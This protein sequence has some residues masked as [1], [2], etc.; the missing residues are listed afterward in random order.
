MNHDPAELI[1]IVGMA[2]RFPGA[3]DTESLW[4]LMMDRGNAIRPVPSERWDAESQLDPEKQVQA[5]G[6][7][8]EDVDQFDPLFFGISPREVEDIDPQQ[9]LM[10]EA[11]WRALE[12]SGMRAEDLRGSRTGVY[13]GAQWHDYELVRKDAGSGA[14]E[15]SSVGQAL[16]VIAAR[17]SYFMRFTG[18]SLTVATGCSSS[19]VALHLATQALRNGEIE[20]AVVGGVNLMLSPDVSIGLTHFGG[21]SPDGR[22]AAFSAAANGFVRGE[23]VAALYLKTLERALADGD[24]VHAVIV[25]TV[26]NNDGGGESLVTPR[27]GAQEDLLRTAYTA[28]GIPLDKLAYVEAHGTG[29]RRGDPVEAGA[30]GRVIGQGR[31]SGAG[32]IAVGSVKSNIGHLEPASGMAG[33]FKAVLSLEHRVVPPSLHADELNPEIPFDELNVAVVREPLPLPDGDIYVGVNSFGWGGTNGHAV[34]M[35]APPQAARGPRP[36][37]ARTPAAEPPAAGTPAVPGPVLVPLSG[38]TDEAL[39]RRAEDIRELV[40]SGTSSVDALA[41]TLAWRR[42]SFPARA[43]FVAQ[44]ADGLADA[45]GR[46]AAD[47]EEEIAGVVTGR[48]RG[49]GR[50]AF[51]FPGQGSQWAR[52]GSELYAHKPVFAS[53]IHRCAKALEPYVDWD[54]AEI[55]SGE[56]GDAWLTRNDMVQP[57]LWAVSV[58]IAEMWRAAGVE[59]DVVIGHSQGE[60]TAATVAGILSYED[61]ALIIARR[62]AL[63]ARTSGRGRMLAVELDVAAAHQALDGFEGLVSLAVNNGPTSCVLSGDTD[64]VEALKE[65]LEAEGVFCRMVNV[66][67]ASHSPQMDELREDLFAA[68][69]SVGPK[70]GTI[71]LMSTVRVAELAGPEMDAGY[72]VD[73][74]RRPVLFADAMSG[75]FDEGITHVVEISPHAV[76]APAIERLAALRDDQPAVLTSLRRDAGSPADL[77]TAFARAYV[78]GLAPFGGLPRDASAPVPGYPWQRTSYWLDT[79]SRR[80]VPRNGFDFAL[81]PAPSEHD[82]WQGTLELAV[83]SMPWLEDHKVDDA[84][85]LPGAGM[86][87]LALGAARSR[88]G[89]LPAT[90]SDVAFTSDL[91]LGDEPARLSALWRD[92]IT[93][94]GSFTLLSLPEGETAWTVH[95]TARTSQR[96]ERP[97]PVAFPAHLLDAE[98]V[99]GEEFYAACAARG[100]HYGPAFQGVQRLYTGTSGAEGTSRDDASPE[101]ASHDT[102][103]HDTAALAEVR[104]SDRCRAGA[105]PH[106]LHPALWD[107]ALQACLALCEDGQTVVPTAVH[108]V[109]VLREMAEPVL[110]LWSYAVRRAGYRFDLYFF[111]GDR[112]PLMIM[113]GLELSP[114]AAGGPAQDD[115]ERE[116]RLAFR[117]EPRPEA[118]S[119]P[120]HWFVCGAPTASAGLA[121]AL[122]AA[123]A[124][125]TL[126]EGDTDTW[127]GQL[128]SAGD[129]TGVV[130]A[131]PDARAGLAAQRRALVTLPAVI[132][133]CV[134]RT[135]PPR[136]ALV[137]TAA[138]AVDDEDRPDPGAALF[139]G[140]SRVLRREHSELRPMVIDLAPGEA[141]TGCAAELLTGD[142]EDQVAL[143]GGRRLVGR[144][145]RGGPASDSETVAAPWR[146][147]DQPFRLGSDRPGFWDSLVYRP[148]SRTAPGPGEIEIEITAA[149]LNFIDVMKAMGTYPDPSGAASLLGGECAGRVGAVGEGVTGFAVGD[150]VVACAMG[151]IASHVT[152]LAAHAQA[153]PESLDD[154]DAAALPLVMGTAWYGLV[155]LGRLT[156]GERVLIHSG[157]GGLG[158]AAIQIAKALGAE[159]IATAGSEDKRAYLRGLGIEHV[160]D[161]RNLSW[162]EGVR[163]ATGG[164]GV[165]VVLNSLTGAAIPLGL[166]A[167]AEDGRFIEVG[168]KDIYG[169]RN[170]SLS[171]FRK[172]ISFAAVDLAGLMTRRPERFARVFGQVWE[173]VADGR[174][175]PLPVLPYTFADAAEALREM[176]HGNHIGKF[177]LAGPG[178][179]AG[180]APEAMPGGRF[181]ADASYL[182]TGGLGALGLSLA[183]FLAD[184]GAGALALVSRSQPG[185]DAAAR[186]GELRERGVRVET[187]ACDVSDESA[188]RETLTRLRTELPPLRGVVHAAGLLDDA[189]VLNARPEQ[190]E[191]VLAPKVDGARHLD[192]ATANDPLDFFVMFSSAAALV[193]NTGQ[194]AYAAGNAYMDTLAEARRRRGFPALSVQW[195]PFAE[196]GLAAE[197][198]GRGARLSDRGM[199]SFPVEDAWAAL[200]RFLGRD[201]QVVGYVPLNLRQWFDAYP[202]TAA[203]KSWHLLRRAL[204][205][206]GSSAAAGGEFRS[207]FEAADDTARQSLVEGRV[208]EVAARVMRMDPKAIDR[209]TPFKSLGLDSL[210]SLEL[211]NRLESAFGLQLSPTLLWTYGNTRALSGVLGERLLDSASTAAPAPAASTASSAS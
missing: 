157:T 195:G 205:E 208:R 24:Q 150:R 140:F 179:V 3:P 172:G 62:S 34:L 112:E 156:A 52:M 158:L 8:L 181:R 106:T 115:S 132:R 142:G 13:V 137:T 143:R 58:G 84:V 87:A 30:I 177:V 6:G 51:V 174:I 54:L 91:T 71:P 83:D 119:A 68:L 200:V 92:D 192:A 180:V 184:R 109:H 111:T 95:A 10:L 20:G 85:V 69:A 12:D 191:R 11:G 33:L 161:S 182:L 118:A 190:I 165:D 144:L 18:P 99:G 79:G 14:T 159:V 123:G 55:V 114:L 186:I 102:A 82:T 108:R 160:F 77:T 171:A 76:L 9:R 96:P 170:I 194:A 70:R 202:D 138:Q 46:F 32:P 201:Q 35:S 27:T 130:F 148:L 100:L 124:P 133:A 152:V 175:E 80:S 176:S 57:T 94:G 17:L 53:V 4:K 28:G 15:R 199:D 48:A 154:T 210:M 155:E 86:V 50:T 153:V 21:L 105:R 211:R 38:H 41:G 196:I 1:A 141:A 136:F 63:A 43:A 103:P 2:G 37:A 36:P 139:W 75:L 67:Y 40:A 198:D 19:M 42:D 167:L 178:T 65:I 189:T 187:Y 122:H 173:L 59:P 78:S 90:L 120:G 121:E 5:V 110:D 29:T 129:I 126:A 166:D 204:Q 61:G 98:P 127:A 31:S 168:K 16:D 145:T 56:A 45:L 81:T 117:E 74:L 73:N 66:D 206:G 151:A 22:C 26:V 93:E 60:V 162:A 72:W 185:A 64:A 116:H 149:A 147:S 209:E 88:H 23:G 125:V 97:A 197:D 146:T 188:V 107:G 39:R 47:P 44:D 7:F 183:E 203:Q 164:Q 128:A 89:V 135:A 163:A 104:L 131:A 193:G 207:L 113:E 25:R 134:E 101:T 49:R 169:A